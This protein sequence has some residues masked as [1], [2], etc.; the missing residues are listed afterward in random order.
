MNLWCSLQFTTE[1]MN[2]NSAFMTHYLTL[3]A[4]L[5]PAGKQSSQLSWLWW[6]SDYRRIKRHLWNSVS[7][8]LS[9]VY[10]S[11]RTRTSATGQV[12]HQWLAAN[13]QQ[14][15]AREPADE[16]NLPTCCCLVLQVLLCGLSPLL[17]KGLILRST[18]VRSQ[19]WERCHITLTTFSDNKLE[20]EG[21]T[22][23]GKWGLLWLG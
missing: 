1:A 2:H 23:F 8:L 10:C 19:G 4:W 9:S 12:V 3:P 20:Y 18:N 17:T 21:F 15:P 22:G 14:L 13:Q 5:V 11:N 16:T 7:T 6:S